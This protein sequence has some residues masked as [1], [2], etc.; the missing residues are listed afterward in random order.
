[1]K[2]Y[3]RRD[4]LNRLAA[5][6]AIAIGGRSFTPGRY[7]PLL[8]FSTLGCPDWSFPKIVTFA[9]ENGYA[10]IEIR[11]IKRELDLPKCPE[12][13][14]KENIMSTRKLVKDNGV[15]IINLGAS[16]NLHLANPAERKK[17]LDEAKRF[18]D[19]AAELQCPFIRVFPNNFPKDQER[20]A[21][22]N[23][24]VKGLAELGDY[25]KG[26]RVT[27]LMETHGEVVKSDDLEII[28]K[29]AAHPQ[30]GLI[31]DIVNMWAVTKEKP[32]DVYPKLKK[33]IRHTHLKDLSFING[34]EQYTLF[35][36]GE[37]PVFEAVDLLT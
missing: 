28:M 11:G 27:V 1:M 23:L 9:K 4:F 6:A 2:T 30:V 21:T 26:S 37:T 14:S 3:P 31:W 34:K 8:S 33:Y 13:S 15:K 29:Q 10:G 32:A 22:I 35:G 18:I 17:N 19:L 20:A 24:I 16:S 7:Q 36:K 5:L 12:F 25:A